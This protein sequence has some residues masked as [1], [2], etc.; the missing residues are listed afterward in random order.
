V[1]SDPL[2]KETSYNLYK[3]VKF[4]FSFEKSLLTCWIVRDKK[5]VLEESKT[6]IIGRLSEKSPLMAFKKKS[7][8]L[9]KKENLTHECSPPP[10][11]KKG[12]EKG[13]EIILFF[14][15]FY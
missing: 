13:V 9:K 6:F 7:F 10:S 15:V 2:K 8:F 4:S 14:N 3:S 12:K 1:S 11:Q 5:T